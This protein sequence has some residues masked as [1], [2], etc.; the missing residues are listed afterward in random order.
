[1]LFG[2]TITNGTR[3]RLHIVKGDLTAFCGANI[4]ENTITATPDKTLAVCGLCKRSIGRI[5]KDEIPCPE[6]LKKYQKIVNDPDAMRE[7]IEAIAEAIY[8]VL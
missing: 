7:R 8:R 4:V 1:M 6:H 2:N 5:P 3:N